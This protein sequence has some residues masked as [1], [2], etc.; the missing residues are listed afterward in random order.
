MIV[1]RVPGVSVVCHSNVMTALYREAV[2]FLP[3]YKCSS[4]VAPGG[5]DRHI[6]GYRISTQTALLGDPHRIPFS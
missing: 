1:A 2:L 6:S 4:P 5:F 3:R